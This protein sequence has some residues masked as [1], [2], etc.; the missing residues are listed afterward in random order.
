MEITEKSLSH[1]GLQ[2]S[3]GV[4]T[5]N[6]FSSS[7]KYPSL[8]D[9]PP[10]A[11]AVRT[12]REA[13]QPREKQPSATDSRSTP[14]SGSSVSSLFDAVKPEDFQWKSRFSSTKPRSAAPVFRHDIESGEARR[15]NEDETHKGPLS[16]SPVVSADRSFPTA[17]PPTAATVVSATAESTPAPL[18]GEV[19]DRLVA[20]LLVSSPESGSSAVRI[21]LSDTSA[22]RG[23]DITL[24]RRE[25]GTLSVSLVNEDPRLCESLAAAQGRLCA[26]LSASE[27]RP[28]CVTVGRSDED[29]SSDERPTYSKIRRHS[30]T[31]FGQL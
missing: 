14:S 23:T 17:T 20:R 15:S 1:E 29:E 22:L 7:E 16:E 25:D 3:K 21:T 28:V 2:E 8:S 4:P 6:L 26:Q 10:T 9:E 12:F 11:E 18:D 27:K 31:A 24:S 5:D 13:M 30:D 19:L